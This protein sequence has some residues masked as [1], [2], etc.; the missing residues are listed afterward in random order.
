VKPIQACRSNDGFSLIELMLAVGL[1]VV[2]SGV[3][4]QA[5]LSDGRRTQAFAQRL[6]QRTEQ[7]RTLMLIKADIL[8]S[9]AV[10][11]NPDPDL[12]SCPLAGRHP[13]LQIQSSVG[14]ITYSLGPPP[15]SIW[16][17]QVLMRCG[18]GYSLDGSFSASS[19]MQNRVVIDNLPKMSEGPFLASADRQTGSL[20]LRLINSR[21]FV[22]LPE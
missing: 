21:L 5:L 3:M 6:R 18:P 1:G 12:S 4:L 11:D 2:L 20:Q 8:Q 10:L 16:R 9:A 7:R 19:F 22:E 15:S 14:V 13:V 17:R